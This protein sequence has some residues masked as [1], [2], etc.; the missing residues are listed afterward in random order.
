MIQNQVGAKSP[1]LA[2]GGFSKLRVSA[3]QN[4]CLGF[5][6]LA[7]RLLTTLKKTHIYK[8]GIPFLNLSQLCRILCCHYTC[9]YI[10]AQ[11]SKD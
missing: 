7:T 3:T 11:A 8:I 1:R 5:T 6:P 9:A 10:V 2:S 4:S